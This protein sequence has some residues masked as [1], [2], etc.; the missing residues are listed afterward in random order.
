MNTRIYYRDPD[1]LN[2]KV[3]N[4]IKVIGQDRLIDMTGS[5][6]IEFEQIPEK[7]KS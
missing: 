2:D 7:K 3:I 4:L 6:Q 5:K 1:D